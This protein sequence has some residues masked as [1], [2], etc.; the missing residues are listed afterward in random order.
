V[1]GIPKSYRPQSA[2]KTQIEAIWWRNGGGM[3]DRG[4]AI[5]RPRKRHMEGQR[6][7]SD[8]GRL[9]AAPWP[10]YRR[11]KQNSE[12]NTHSKKSVHFIGGDN[13]ILET[14]W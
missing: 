12:R 10:L 14:K 1:T 3:R 11:I 6:G 7:R 13:E 8:P 5:R 9:Q 4:G 2:Q